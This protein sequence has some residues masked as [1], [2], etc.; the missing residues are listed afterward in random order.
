[1]NMNNIGERMKELQRIGVPAAFRSVRMTDFPESIRTE[2]QSYRIAY[3][4]EREAMGTIYAPSVLIQCPGFDSTRFGV[5][6]LIMA[7]HAAYS[8]AFVSFAQL[9]A[10][11]TT[12]PDANDDG[13]MPVP[14]S[15][16]KAAHALLIDGV[17]PKLLD[18][19]RF[20]QAHFNAFVTQRSHEGRPT[21]ITTSPDEVLHP[22]LI[23]AL[24]PDLVRIGTNRTMAEA[25]SRPAPAS[26]TRRL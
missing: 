5:M 8:A 10:A 6:V 26:P 3:L 17:T 12:K 13:D 11:H 9:V 24:G 2:L 20:N 22:G 14:I 4:K 23:T 1:M 19:F 21:I 16:L 7:R 18:N 25:A 15:R